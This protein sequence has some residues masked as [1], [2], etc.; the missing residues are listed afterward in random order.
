MEKYKFK[1]LSYF[2]QDE[3]TYRELR[4]LTE[5]CDYF[6]YEKF[7]V[8]LKFCKIAN[9]KDVVVYIDDTNCPKKQLE[10]NI[11]CAEL[12][13]REIEFN[14][15][16]IY[17]L[18]KA[19]NRDKEIKNYISSKNYDKWIITVGEDI[20][21]ELYNICTAWNLS[22][23]AVIKEV[24]NNQETHN[25]FLFGTSLY[26]VQNKIYGEN[27][28]MYLENAKNILSLIIIKSNFN[29]SRVI[30]SKYDILFERGLINI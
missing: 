21:F 16:E 7:R 6:T 5:N 22:E 25:V 26:D 19:K 3:I 11:L 13:N 4:D 20:P 2:N 28:N 18:L 15:V 23:F 9:E 10:P 29:L 12:K 24:Y 1:G 8:Y 14:S 30:K 17:A 27:I